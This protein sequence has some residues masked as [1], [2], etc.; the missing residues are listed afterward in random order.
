MWKSKFDLMLNTTLAVAPDPILGMAR[1]FRTDTR[2]EKIDA[3]VGL[4]RDERGETFT[5]KVVKLAY[6]KLSLG[7]GDYIGPD[8]DEEYLGFRTFL[9]EAAKLVFGRFAKELLVEKKLV[10]IGTVGGTGAVSLTADLIK[11][12]D[13]KSSVVIGIPTWP[14]HQ[15]IFNSRKIKVIPVNHMQD[16]MFDG[17]S[18]F[19]A[20]KNSPINS[21]ILFHA[22]LTHNPTGVNPCSE[23]EWRELAGLMKGRLAIFDTPY[24]GFG[25]GL[26][27]DLDAI[28]IFMKEGV[29][30]AVCISF[31]KNAGLYKERPGV[32]FIPTDSKKV[33]LSLQRLLNLLARVSYSS[34]PALGER[35]V[36]QVLSDQKMFGSWLTELKEVS[37]L[38]KERREIFARVL[39]E[40]DFVR[41]QTGMFSL[42]SIPADKIELL[43]RKH[44]VYMLQS[45][46]INFGGITKRETARLAKLMKDVI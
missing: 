35:L 13:T 29:Q 38:L 36:G 7:A 40:F 37:G 20:I 33:A 14:N 44:A 27:E 10:A 42:L 24:A 6:R 23:S 32:L 1:I 34:P 45:G 26:V 46:R 5:P 18:Y 43:R 19:R 30:V 31:A 12:L 28:R 11:R 41:S 39:P 25:E 15:Q 22:G 21:A 2:V 8:G 3:G 17:A 9:T 16:N 4:F